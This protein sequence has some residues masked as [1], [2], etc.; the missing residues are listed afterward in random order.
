MFINLTPHDLHIILDNETLTIPASGTVAR[1]ATKRRHL[2]TLA[3]VPI[4][5]VTYGE[6]EGLPE[7]RGDDWLIVS[8]MTAAAAPDRDDLLIP[9]ELVRDEAG[10]IIG[11]RGLTVA[12][13]Q[14]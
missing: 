2:F 13:S 14:Q 4:D 1:V 7:P 12:N 11:C 6:V 9:G 8:A 3:G 10:Q 5:R